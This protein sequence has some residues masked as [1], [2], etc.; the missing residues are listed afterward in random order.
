MGFPLGACTTETK[1]FETREAV[2]LGAQEIDMVLN[3]GIF[4]EEHYSFIKQDIE[5]VRESVLEEKATKTGRV[6]EDE[7]IEGMSK[8]LQDVANENILFKPNDGPQE[9]FLA[10]QQYRSCTCHTLA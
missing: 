4:H 1:A 6:L 8:P 3:V 10:W 7:Y 5:K 2:N 9:D